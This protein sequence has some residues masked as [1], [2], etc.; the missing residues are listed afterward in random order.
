MSHLS[1]V[2]KLKLLEKLCTEAG[3]TGSSLIFLLICDLAD[4]DEFALFIGFIIGEECGFDEATS[5]PA[6]FSD[7][8]LANSFED[9][10]KS[11]S[12]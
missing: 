1:S 5:P 11:S 9:G 10:S 7:L 12:L 6:S 2:L 8:C 4:E 3:D